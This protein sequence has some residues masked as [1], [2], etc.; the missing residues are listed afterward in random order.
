MIDVA[1]VFLKKSALLS[2]AALVC[3]SLLLAGCA[4]GS[5]GSGG[6]LDRLPGNNETSEEKTAKKAAKQAR[7]AQQAS[8]RERGTLSRP[9]NEEQ[10]AKRT[11]ALQ[12]LK[13]LRDQLKKRSPRYES[14][15]D[16]AKAELARRQGTGEITDATADQTPSSIR[17]QRLSELETLK[18]ELERRDASRG[19][20]EELIAAAL[21]DN[22]AVYRYINA[23]LQHP[24]G[25]FRNAFDSQRDLE[26]VSSEKAGPLFAKVQGDKLFQNADQSVL[27]VAANGNCDISFTTANLKDYMKGLVHVLETQGAIVSSKKVLSIDIINAVHPRGNF[28]LSTGKKVIG[29]GGSTEFYT[30]ISVL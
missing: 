23:C 4:G 11:E 24:T 16:A 9:S 26:L 22:E 15:L 10:I 5:D 12:E 8:F 29:Q 14:E 19:T 28:R 27:T 18:A 3:C 6:L 20:Q 13:T 2:S 21:T 30:T 7:K 25:D 17:D 1:S